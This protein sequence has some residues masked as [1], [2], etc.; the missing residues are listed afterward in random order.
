MAV[1]KQ[2]KGGPARTPE[3]TLFEQ[4]QAGCADSLNALMLRHERLI[5]RVVQQQWLCTRYPMKLP[6]RKGGG[7]YGTPSWAMTQGRETPSQ[8]T[9]TQQ[10]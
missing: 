3:A 8:P 10:L 5:H 9:P 2:G 4:A 1:I 7:G 6:S